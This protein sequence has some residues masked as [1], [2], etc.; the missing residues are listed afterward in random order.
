MVTRVRYGTEIYSKSRDKFTV[1]ES[2]EGTV[3]TDFIVYVR[4]YG[5]LDEIKRSI[6]NTIIEKANNRQRLPSLK[7]SK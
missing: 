2:L 6:V 1:K 5:E 7:R 4:V 3:G